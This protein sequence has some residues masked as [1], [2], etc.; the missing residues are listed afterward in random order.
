MTKGVKVRVTQSHD[1]CVIGDEAW[2]EYTPRV[3][4]LINAG[5]FEVIEE[6][7]EDVPEDPGPLPEPDP[8]LGEPA[9]PDDDDG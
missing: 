6:T 9:A 4:G 7:A 8:E 5:V 2:V 3:Q 1:D